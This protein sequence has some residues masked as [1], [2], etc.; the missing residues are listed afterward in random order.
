[1]PGR[2]SRASKAPEVFD[3]EAEAA[4][5]QFAKAPESSALAR[6]SSV[7]PGLRRPPFAGGLARHALIALRHEDQSWAQSYYLGVVL[8]AVSRW[9]AD[10]TMV[11]LVWCD[12]PKATKGGWEYK[13]SGQRDRVEARMVLCQ[14]RELSGESP[15]SSGT[16][17]K[18]T[19]SQSE[20][21]YILDIQREVD[22]HV[23]EQTVLDTV[24][25]LVRQYS[26]E[27][28]AAAAAMAAATASPSPPSARHKRHRPMPLDIQSAD[29]EMQVM[30]AG[31]RTPRLLPRPPDAWPERL[32]QEERNL[33]SFVLLG[34]AAGVKS[35][36]AAV[37]EKG[38]AAF[39][40]LVT[41][42]A[43]I[44]VVAAGSQDDTGTALPDKV[45]AEICAVLLEAG[46]SPTAIDRPTG[47]HALHVAAARGHTATM[48][49][50]WRHGRSGGPASAA[51][52]RTRAIDIDCRCTSG[53]TALHAACRAA[54]PAAVRSLLQW[55]ANPM[56]SDYTHRRLPCDV[57]GVLSAND[58]DLVSSGTT[59]AHRAT[60]AAAVRAQLMQ[61]FPSLRIAIFSHKDCLEHRTPVN[62]QESPLR[63]PA[64]L[65]RLH[66]AFDTVAAPGAAS[67]AKARVKAEPKAKPKSAGAAGA[68]ASKPR[69]AKSIEVTITS[70]ADCKACGGAH[71]A[72]TC[73]KAHVMRPK[74]ESAAGAAAAG[75]GAAGGSSAGAEK[76]KKAQ[77]KKASR[78]QPESQLQLQ[79]Q[80]LDDGGQNG[81]AESSN[82]SAGAG[83]GGASSGCLVYRE[84]F[85]PATEDSVRA[86][87][88]PEYVEFLKNLDRAIS[89]ATR[90]GGQG[91]SGSGSAGGPGGL[92]PLPS[93]KVPLT[94]AVQ[95]GLMQFQSPDIK[96]PE[97][98]DTMFTKGSLKAAYR[99]AGSVMAAVDGVMD[100]THRRAFCAVRPPGHHAGS[101]GLL[102]DAVSCGFCVFNN[103]CVGAMHALA[104]DPT[105]RVAIV[106]FDVH[107]G[108]GSEEIVSRWLRAFHA[109]EQEAQQQAAGQKQQQQQQQHRAQ[110]QP[111]LWFG[112]I[113]LYHSSRKTP[114]LSVPP[115]RGPT[116]R[117]LARDVPVE[118]DAGQWLLEP[119]SPAA[120]ASPM[121]DDEDLTT[122][123]TGN[124]SGSGGSSSDRGGG[125]AASGSA[126][127]GSLDLANPGNE[128]ELGELELEFY[129]GTGARDNL[130]LNIVNAP[131]PPLWGV[132]QTFTGSSAAAAAAGGNDGGRAGKKRKKSAGGAAASSPAGAAASSES[133][134]ADEYGLPPA[135]S[136]G[137]V[138]FRHAVVTRLLPALRA[139]SPGLLLLSAGFDGAHLDQGN[140]RGQKPGLDLQPEDFLWL[141]EQ[142]VAV[143]NLSAN[144]RIVS[145]LEGGYGKPMEAGGF[146]RSVLATNCEAHV[147]G[148]AGVPFQPMR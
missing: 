120:A 84:D 122:D 100:G 45:S 95:R 61:H 87:H 128:E 6:V 11:E 117:P 93:P 114:T 113:H 119:C 40:N 129:P 147:A 123:T 148:L 70:E 79:L 56:L 145:V 9:S 7:S 36:L 73:A 118:P 18:V 3:P 107:H 12:V 68:A 133:S 14:L 75:A 143:A 24:D 15:L 77:K 5:P 91:G 50:L 32:T 103:V 94:P 66:A 1:M 139:Y 23:Q 141:T 48:A 35:S 111:P 127:G 44:L 54:Q 105:L 130:M 144:G 2:P 30:A 88:R 34:D 74:T 19:C 81:G 71:R 76:G 52:R 31:G 67:K 27:S 116:R 29:G 62:H 126:S 115:E 96:T 38:R 64:I 72:H 92:P 137:R 37:N 142:L 63:I 26:G 121:E 58:R 60:G 53:E 89:A 109:K 46:A 43:H 8:K 41:G 55:G 138:A 124:S 59:A 99:A 22:E 69:P 136:A 82:R 86:V 106:D 110:Q 97:N 140:L 33:C 21:R 80:P 57:I 131:L 51:S 4:K 20:H 10:D 49:V 102:S 112:S 39:A 104:R 28:A 146:D 125:D 98:S 78:S 90:G 132:R 108:N 65:D 13:V 135:S 101:L 25:N 17:K 85:A 134:L 42:G 16:P 83:A 47:H